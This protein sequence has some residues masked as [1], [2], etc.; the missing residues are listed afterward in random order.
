MGKFTKEQLIAKVWKDPT[1]KKKL[2]TN[3][4]QT[5][6]EMGYQIPEGI[7]VRVVED[8]AK[9]L[10][11]VIPHAPKE[12]NELSEKELC[13]LAGGGMPHT[14]FSGWDCF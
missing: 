9:T 6:I 2:L 3:P 7:N 8:D 5:L 13:N 4:K 10:T 12:V 1:F 14:M 11:F